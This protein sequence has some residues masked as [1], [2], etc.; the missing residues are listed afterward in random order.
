M[1]RIGKIISGLICFIAVGSC[2]F[3][4]VMSF[5]DADGEISNIVWTEE[6]LAEYNKRPDS[7]VVDYYDVYEDHYFTEDGYFSVSK[8]RYMPD[9]SQWQMTV[10]YNKSSIENLSL[11]Y[12]RK[13]SETDNEFVFA[14]MDNEGVLY[15]EFSYIKTVKGRYTYYRLVFDDIDI[16][17]LNELNL[18]IYFADD[19]KDGEYPEKNIG[20]LP[21]Y[22]AK[23]PRDEY[24][25]EDELPEDN[26]PTKGLLS[27]DTLL[28]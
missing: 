21:V 6:A 5:I 3:I 24:D 2:V 9:I 18:H 11:D 26:K 22:N 4:F 16:K 13:L 28:K 14:I 15:K 27:G 10:R 1:K 12:D 23:M 19:I 17:K 25:F 7:F 8:I 20:V